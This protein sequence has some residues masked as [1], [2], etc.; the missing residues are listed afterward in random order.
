M[1]VEK[2]R[3]A[4]NLRL[5]MTW[6][7]VGIALLA[8]FLLLLVGGLVSYGRL[9][10]N[11]L[12]PGLHVLSVPVGG[13]TREEARIQVQ[14]AV[15]AALE[16]GL[17]FTYKGKTV[18]LDVSG[19]A[20]NPD[21]A[22]DLLSYRVSDAIDRAYGYARTGSW[23]QQ[24]QQQIRLR[25]VQKQIPVEVDI[26][27]TGISDGLK[28]AF[29]QD[30]ITPQDAAI[31]I[32]TSTGEVMPKI[33]IVPEIRGT[34]LL[35]DRAIDNLQNETQ[36][37][38][39]EPIV[40]L[41]Q[42]REPLVTKA[43]L[44]A[45]LPKIEEW[46]KRPALS[47]TYDKKTVPIPTST[48]AGWISLIPDTTTIDIMLNSTLF[49]ASMRELFPHVEQ[50]GKVGGL[51]LKDGKVESFTG[52]TEGIAFDG[53]ATLKQ[54]I[55]EW[56]TTTTF[57]LVT[58]RTPAKL[59]GIDPETL[60]IKELLGVGKSEFSGSPSNRRKNI[61]LGLAKVNGTLLQ[62][63]EEFS[64]IKVLGPIDG[65][66]QWL[67][68]LVI[69]GNETTP[70]FGGGLCQV[71]TTVFRGTLR[72]G[73]PVVERRNHSYRVRYYEP[74]GTDATIYDPKPDYRF[75]NDTTHPIY[76][77]AYVKG[78][79]AFVEYWGTKDGRIADFP[80]KPRVYNITSPP[81]MKL[82]ETTNLPPGK[83]KCT[84]TAHAG[85]DAEFTYSVTY[86][87][88]EVKSEVFKSHYRPWQAVCLIGVEKLSSDSGTASVPMS[89][90][91]GN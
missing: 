87:N 30:V 7:N 33:T 57:P 89:P 41:D 58:I 36:D 56:P 73:L 82:V 54:V 27:R 26:F 31:Q 18:S 88:G 47:F 12:F 21:A 60:G 28:Q 4:Q 49:E 86:P 61:A 48:F 64:L 6:I 43:S 16:K 50:E 19:D 24:I 45:L 13:M 83:K 72:A 74:V 44:E 63:G 3:L 70:E 17:P 22:R 38:R 2:K 46:L 29:A 76:L 69:K 15:D 35:F 85:A 39:F 51:V 40:L 67:P 53:K 25:L 34:E 81:P 65:E 68:E 8:F 66:H 84:E 10:E 90:D 14:S 5:A 55:A 42:V 91:A 77:H 23:Q 80:E 71:G 79:E 75:K 32:S 52:G 11:R 78:D 9:Y 59:T 62:P 37:L 1:A 20:M